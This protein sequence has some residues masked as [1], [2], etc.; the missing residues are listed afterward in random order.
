MIKILKETLTPW[1]DK[2]GILRCQREIITE[3]YVVEFEIRKSNCPKCKVIKEPHRK[4]QER[5]N[6]R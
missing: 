1:V 6:A 4:K 5:K 3:P 2:K